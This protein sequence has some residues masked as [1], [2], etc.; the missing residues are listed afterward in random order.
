[1]YVPSFLSSCFIFFSSFILPSFFVL[2]NFFPF[3]PSSPILLFSYFFLLPRSLFPSRLLR[4][5]KYTITLIATR[6]LRFYDRSCNLTIR[7]F[8][9]EKALGRSSSQTCLHCRE[10]SHVE[11]LGSRHVEASAIIIRV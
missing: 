1:M 11:S 4:D 9:R 6:C 10:A 3:F 7:V 2:F 8:R 5:A